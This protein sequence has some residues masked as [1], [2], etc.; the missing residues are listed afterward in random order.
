VTRAGE[1]PNNGTCRR[2]AK[3]SDLQPRF[4]L[5]SSQGTYV[6]KPSCTAT[7]K[8]QEDLPDLWLI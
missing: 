1:S 7:F 4:F 6:G 5:D 8:N 2:T 3:A